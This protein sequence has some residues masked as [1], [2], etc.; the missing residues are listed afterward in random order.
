MPLS[1]SICLNLIGRKHY[2]TICGHKFH[3][4]CILK[5]ILINDTCP[6]C[7]AILR[8]PPI[9][10]EISDEEIQRISDVFFLITDAI[11]SRRL[12]SL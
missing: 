4:K 12:S 5:W 11:I 9:I 7:R 2:K 3:C 6:L 10:D 8:T 1:C